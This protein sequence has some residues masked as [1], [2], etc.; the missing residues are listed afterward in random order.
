MQYG[1]L[2]YSLYIRP[3]RYRPLSNCTI[4]S[5]GL[6]TIGKRKCAKC[7]KCVVLEMPVSC[8]AVNCTNRFSKGSGVGFFQ[9]PV[10][11]RKKELWIR[12]ISQVEASGRK[13]EP[14]VHNRICGVHFVSGRPSKD[15]STIDYMPTIFRDAKKRGNARKGDPAREERAAKRSWNKATN[16]KVQNAAS[17]LMDL[18][19]HTEPVIEAKAFVDCGIQVSDPIWRKMGVFRTK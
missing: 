7:T 12:A 8:C 4:V 1:R 18:S 14:S 5:R 3:L 6:L 11:P 17:V 2:V 16:D 15:E 9:F 19:W 10:D 13:W